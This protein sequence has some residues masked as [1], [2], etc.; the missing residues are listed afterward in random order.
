[1][2]TAYRV[3]GRLVD[4]WPLSVAQLERAEPVY[5]TFPGWTDDLG[6]CR[7]IED[8]PHAARRY[9]EAIE[10]RAGVPINIVSL[11]PERT[12]TIV[13]DSAGTAVVAGVGTA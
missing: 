3:D 13:R 6:A 1:V 11:G 4:E 10:T 5:E 7:A 12:Q 2:C 9:L 8:L